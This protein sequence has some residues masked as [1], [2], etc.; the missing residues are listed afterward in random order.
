MTELLR[1]AEVVLG[2]LGIYAFA[3]TV[4]KIGRWIFR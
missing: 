3:W 2:F 1:I 4:E